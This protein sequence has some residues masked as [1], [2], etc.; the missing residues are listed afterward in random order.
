MP[1]GENSQRQIHPDTRALEHLAAHT[2]AGCPPED[3]AATLRVLDAMMH[4]DPVEELARDMTCDAWGMP[5]TDTPLHGLTHQTWIRADAIALRLYDV[6][7]ALAQ[8]AEQDGDL[9]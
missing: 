9:P 6:R 8:A 1:R 3:I 7:Q 2:V 4:P 5:L